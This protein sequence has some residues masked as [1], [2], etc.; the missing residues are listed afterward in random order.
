MC[1]TLSFH[2]AGSESS[3]RCCGALRSSRRKSFCIIKKIALDTICFSLRSTFYLFIS[4]V[5]SL[6]LSLWMAVTL[7]CVYVRTYKQFAVSWQLD[8]ESVKASGNIQSIFGV[9]SRSRVGQIQTLPSFELFIVCDTENTKSVSQPFLHFTNQ[10][11]KRK[12]C[13]KNIYLINLETIQSQCGPN[14]HWWIV[15]LS[16]YLLG[17]DIKDVEV[18]SKGTIGVIIWI[19]RA[20]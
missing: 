7:F 16:V 13:H 19:L 11:N 12:R 15:A 8:S 10:N 20:L 4:L 1:I 5:R 17:W 6:F 9:S 14:S 18:Y 3:A 2:R